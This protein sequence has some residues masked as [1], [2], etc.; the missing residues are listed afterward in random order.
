M[1][2]HPIIFTGDSV[3]AILE[4][5]KTQTRRVIRPL[6]PTW[7]YSTVDDGDDGKLWLYN[8]DEDGVYRRANCPFGVPGD[9]LYWAN[10]PIEFIELYDQDNACRSGAKIRSLWDGSERVVFSPGKAG[11]LRGRKIKRPKLGRWRGRILPIEWARDWRWPVTDVRVE[12]VAGISDADC[13]AEGVQPEVVAIGAPNEGIWEPG[14]G[15]AGQSSYHKPFRTL[16]DG[17]NAKWGYGWDVN[18]FVFVV[19]FRRKP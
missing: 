12:R 6:D 16:W 8:C 10:E 13:K 19:T 11:V 4:G 5:R 3:R 14:Y 18:P 7:T 1:K 2:E 9:E 15:A 17:I